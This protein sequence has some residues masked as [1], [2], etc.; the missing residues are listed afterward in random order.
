ML[1]RAVCGCVWN[2]VLGRL[3]PHGRTVRTGAA[4]KAAKGGSV[5]GRA[6][7]RKA[8][9]AVMEQ[10]QCLIF[11]ERWIAEG[12][13]RE[14]RGAVGRNMPR[15]GGGG[16]K[17][18]Y[19][20]PLCRIRQESHVVGLGVM[21]LHGMRY[22][23]RRCGGVGT[24]TIRKR[25]SVGFGGERSVRYTKHNWGGRGTGPVG[26]GT[27]RRGGAVDL[28]VGEEWGAWASEVRGRVGRAI[29]RHNE[30]RGVQDG[31]GLGCRV[32]E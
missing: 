12:A 18:W 30:I 23:E 4:G 11:R 26:G 1:L 32:G 3:S 9:H 14:G 16:R 17:R 8:G 24:W 28:Q 20:F 15:G 31:C 6:L 2:T 5:G 22:V 27:R 21:T 29:S 19:L 13:R 10:A 25:D 7:W